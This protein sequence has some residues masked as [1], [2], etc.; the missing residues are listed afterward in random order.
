MVKGNSTF[1]HKH[2]RIRLKLSNLISKALLIDRSLSKD[3]QVAHQKQIWVYR[4]L[5]VLGARLVA[6]GTESDDT[7]I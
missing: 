3:K 6:Q 7:M 1:L 5:S 2:P 4:P